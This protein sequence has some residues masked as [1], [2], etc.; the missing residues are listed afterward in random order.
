MLFLS[1]VPQNSLCRFTSKNSAKKL[2][3]NLEK[4]GLYFLKKSIS[5]LMHTRK[6]LSVPVSTRLMGRDGFFKVGVGA[7]SCGSPHGNFS[8]N[9]S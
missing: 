4:K 8:F 2:L 3:M 1:E 9:A 7:S 5:K 6:L